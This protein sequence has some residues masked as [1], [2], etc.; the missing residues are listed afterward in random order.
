MPNSHHLALVQGSASSK[1][2]ADNGPFQAA[3]CLQPARAL[4]MVSPPGMG[5]ALAPALD[6]PALTTQRKQTVLC[7]GGM[8][9]NPH[10]SC[11]GERSTSSF[12]PGSSLSTTALLG[13]AVALS[14]ASAGGAWCWSISMA[15]GSVWRG[16]LPLCGSPYSRQ[17]STH[18]KARPS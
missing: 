13:V 3:W 7:A 10:S 1:P 18:T 9:L 8:L 12:S 4:A 16:W 2:W 11:W 14:T 15:L 5:S 6:M 17:L